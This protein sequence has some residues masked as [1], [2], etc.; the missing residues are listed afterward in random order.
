MT[1]L[2]R[3]WKIVFACCIG[4]CCSSSAIPFY[5]LGAFTVP[6]EADFGWS[7]AEI[8]GAISFLTLGGLFTIP[9]AGMLV[10]KY[11][12]RRVALFSLCAFAITFANI[13]LTTS[14][15][16]IFYA[17]WTLMSAL[18]AGTT[19][20]TWTRAVNGWFDKNRGIALGFALTG[21]GLAGIFTPNLATYL[22]QEF[23]WRHAF[24]G[25]SLLPV[26]VA[27]PIVYFFFRDPPEGRN[28]A[29]GEQQ[30]VASV[31]RGVT[32][33]KALKGRYFWTIA[34]AFFL[35]SIGIGGTIPNLIPMLQD[36]GLAPA[37]AAGVVGA[38]GLSVIFGR[39]IAGYLIDRF[40][41]PGVA[42]VMLSLPAVSCMILAGDVQSVG[43]ATIAAAIIGLAAG[44]EFDL[45]SYLTSRYFGLKHYGKIYAWQFA[46]FSLGAGLAPP[47]FGR[48]FDLYGSYRP[49]LIAAAILYV[50]GSAALLTLGKY[51]NLLKVGTAKH[52]Q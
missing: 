33:R 48:V 17:N 44:A 46:A 36:G 32:L 6:L 21:T 49:I 7:R 3:G 37:T 39:I 1:E 41:A 14:S 24:V 43:R 27:L 31:I 34:I 2:Q 22:I 25:L 45:I 38:I 51:P 50:L 10:D 12:P 5:T 42:F 40:W 9:I 19:P 11:G 26:C 35:I 4:I 28:Q 8:Q 47:V 23:G 16:V 18:S 15:L 30:A 20:I 29:A 13:G 52:S